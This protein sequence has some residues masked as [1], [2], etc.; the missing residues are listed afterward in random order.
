[1]VG[2][3]ALHFTSALHGKMRDLLHS[4]LPCL[5]LML[6][7]DAFLRPRE[8]KLKIFGPLAAGLCS[9]CPALVLVPVIVLCL[10]IFMYIYCISVCYQVD[11]FLE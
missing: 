5:E 4:S 7:G 10:S 6:P 9:N 1:M 3:E 11:H 8:V 2:L